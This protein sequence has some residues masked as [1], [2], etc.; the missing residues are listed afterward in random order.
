MHVMHEAVKR[1]MHLMHKKIDQR[2]AMSESGNEKG[3]LAYRHAAGLNE[4]KGNDRG[5][6]GYDG[7]PRGATN[8]KGSPEGRSPM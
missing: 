6:S 7:I 8:A 3:P 1:Y 2:R 4:R 5:R